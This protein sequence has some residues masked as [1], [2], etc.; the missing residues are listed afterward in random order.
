MDQ[1]HQ[2]QTEHFDT[3]LHKEIGEVRKDVK[4][5]HKKID[6]HILVYREN[7]E[8][9]RDLKEAVAKNTETVN[10]LQEDMKLV[11]ELW[12]HFKWGKRTIIGLLSF[13]GLFV[14]VI[15]GIIRLLK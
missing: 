11:M 1:Q 15:W 6:D 13:I 8:A 7:G 12:G 9:M 3:E 5:A 4:K 10:A 2:E 14:G